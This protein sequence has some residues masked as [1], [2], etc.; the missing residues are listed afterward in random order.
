MAVWIFLVAPGVSYAE[1]LDSWS[2]YQ[3][4]TLGDWNRYRNQEIDRWKEYQKVISVKWG[5]DG[6]LPGKKVYAEYFSN[7]D[8]K[9]RI[10]FEKGE[11]RIES[12]NPSRLSNESQARALIQKMVDQGILDPHELKK[13]SQWSKK[14]DHIQGADGVQRNRRTYLLPLNSNHLEI[15]ERRYFPMVVKWSLKNEVDPAFVMAVIERESSFNP[16]AR[17]WVPAYGLMQIVPEYAGAEILHEVP[18]EKFLYDPENNIRVG[19]AYIKLLERGY[20]P[21]MKSGDQKRYLVT[22]SYNWGPHRIKRAIETGRIDPSESPK[23]LF[24]DLL[25]IVPAETR[26]YLMG[27]TE[28]YGKFLDLLG[29]RAPASQASKDKVGAVESHE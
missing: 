27:V 9:I 20:F 19:T 29:R 2:Q 13:G 11:I 7:N 24:Q 22:C 25:T 8:V 15:R 21:E 4:Q 12:L 5:R 3:A 14:E 1:E 23:T 16:R 17:S 18:S 10:D 6:V 26:G 28:S